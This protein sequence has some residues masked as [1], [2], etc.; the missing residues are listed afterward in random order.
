M[1]NKINKQQKWNTEVADFSAAYHKRGEIK[2]LHALE[3]QTAKLFCK[4]SR[5]ILMI[6]SNTEK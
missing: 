6:V 5:K 4:N 3:I 1:R 2:M